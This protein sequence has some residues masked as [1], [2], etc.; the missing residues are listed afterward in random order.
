MSVFA[1]MH[2]PPTK[3][4]Q[5][6]EDVSHTCLSIKMECPYLCKNGRPSQKQAGVDIYGETH[7]GRLVGTRSKN[8]TVGINFETMKTE[9]GNAEK[10]EPLITELWM[11]EQNGFVNA[12]G[13]GSPR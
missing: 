2:I 11:A 6:F 4:W 12:I 3:G 13:T 5:E 10:S 1:R 8:S 7:L 9:V